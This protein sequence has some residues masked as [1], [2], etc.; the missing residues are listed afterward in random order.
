MILCQVKMI[1][2]ICIYVMRK[3][4]PYKQR[5]SQVLSLV[6]QVMFEFIVKISCFVNCSIVADYSMI[7]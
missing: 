6:K 7:L 2:E 1:A 5:N 4:G 3:F